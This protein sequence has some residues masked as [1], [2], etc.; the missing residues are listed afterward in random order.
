MVIIAQETGNGRGRGK[1]RLPLSR[2]ADCISTTK[3]FRLVLELVPS[4]TLSFAEI[5]YNSIQM[6]SI[7]LPF[8][9]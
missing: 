3:T 5:C 7:Y 8:D 6:K 1:T 2:D 4:L 9:Q